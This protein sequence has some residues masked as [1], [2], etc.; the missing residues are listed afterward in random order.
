MNA[1]E[2]LDQ[3]TFWQWVG[4]VMLVSAFGGVLRVTIKRRDQ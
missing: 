2:F 1:W 4:L 3:A